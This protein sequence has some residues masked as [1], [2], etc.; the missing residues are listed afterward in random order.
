MFFE[1]VGDEPR[2]HPSDDSK[3]EGSRI[4]DRKQLHPAQR[5]Q[6]ADK[7]HKHEH[8]SPEND[9]VSGDKFVAEVRQ[10]RSNEGPEKP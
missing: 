3:L 5:P 7:N 4:D 8:A 2:D 1:V 9:E 10:E 6:S